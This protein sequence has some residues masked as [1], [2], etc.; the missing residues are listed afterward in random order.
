MMLVAVVC[1][2]V[3]VCARC[4]VGGE[5]VSE[6][7]ESEREGARARVYVCVC[8]RSRALAI[9]QLAGDVIAG[10]FSLAR[11]LPYHLNYNSTHSHTYSIVELP[12]SN[13]SLHV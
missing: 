9:R 2:G 3:C 5:S 4:R 8:A 10:R 13:N 11:A 12:I 6:R 7:A 1:G